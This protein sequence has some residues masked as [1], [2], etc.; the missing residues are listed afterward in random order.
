MLRR[1]K[2]VAEQ[3]PE[4]PEQDLAWA[5]IDHFAFLEG[6]AKMWKNQHTRRSPYKPARPE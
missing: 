2:E 5:V 6:E 3:R 4:H 1:L